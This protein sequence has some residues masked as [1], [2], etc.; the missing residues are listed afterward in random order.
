MHIDIG[1]VRV[2]T[3]AGQEFILVPSLAA[4]SRIGSPIEVVRTFHDLHH[5]I[6]RDARR[7]A[8]RVIWACC[9]DETISTVT[10]DAFTVGTWPDSEMLIIAQHLMRHGI[11]GTAK[12]KASSKRD[13][14]QYADR[15]D[16]SEYI[17]AAMIHLGLVRADAEILTMTQ[18]QRMIDSK[19]PKKPGV[20]IGREEYRAAMAKLKGA[21]NG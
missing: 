2:E 11:I 12:P 7:A 13:Q 8:I 17:D 19:H 6:L 10:G 4:M 14:G 1:H 3:G 21:S 5:P 18:L 9:D 15:F 16:P 20:E